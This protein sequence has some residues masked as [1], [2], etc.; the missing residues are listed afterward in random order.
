MEPA[1]PRPK[2]SSKFEKLRNE[3]DPVLK[4]EWIEYPPY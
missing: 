2:K 3:I 1:Q 4:Q